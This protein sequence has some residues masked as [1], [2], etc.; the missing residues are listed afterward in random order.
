M[1]PRSLTMSLIRTD[2]KKYTQDE[3]EPLISNLRNHIL[4]ELSPTSAILFGSSVL[5]TF[6]E[7]SDFD[8]VLIYPTKEDARNAMKRITKFRS[9]FD[10]SIDCI[11]VDSESFQKNSSIGGIYFVAKTE[12]R[13]LF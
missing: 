5:G 8:V 6:D 3:L 1:G 9:H 13:V 11:F 10:R 4:K 12:G 2:T 7:Y